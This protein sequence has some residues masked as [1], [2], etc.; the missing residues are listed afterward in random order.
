[1]LVSYSR[2]LVMMVGVSNNL[3][4]KLSQPK[5]L[6]VLV[7]CQFQV[8]PAYFNKK[9]EDMN[10]FSDMKLTISRPEDTKLN[11]IVELSLDRVLR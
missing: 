6:T 1:M 10:K 4:L 8:D 9:I 5:H 7:N 11:A 2:Q 3:A